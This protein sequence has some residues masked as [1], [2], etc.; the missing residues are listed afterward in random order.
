MGSWIGRVAARYRVTV[1]QLCG[2]GG[3]ALDAS[4]DLG[5]LMHA[6]LLAEQLRRLARLGR[7]DPNR[8]SA[9]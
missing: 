8:I 4:G 7:L 1:E 3:I 6:P 9:I 2:D 5:W